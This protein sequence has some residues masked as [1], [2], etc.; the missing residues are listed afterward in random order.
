[1]TR[2]SRKMP[3]FD[4]IKHKV[5]EA[6]FFLHY[7]KQH[8]DKQRDAAK[9]PACEFSYYLSAFL[10]A[11]STVS[12]LMKQITPKW[13]EQLDKADRAVH[14]LF[15][16]M[17]GSAVHE[18]DVETKKRADKVQV[19]FDP[20]YDLHGQRV[21]GFFFQDM[22]SDVTTYA[23]THSVDLEGAEREV[24]ELCEAYLTILRRQAEAQATNR[25]TLP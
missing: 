24:I 18:G 10:S 22:F 5:G 25:Q 20:N 16:K 12:D 14:D 1:M 8:R 19:R 4:Q 13:W 9:P 21:Q 23:E 11:A 17:R 3:S 15:W 2:Q 6:H 7:L